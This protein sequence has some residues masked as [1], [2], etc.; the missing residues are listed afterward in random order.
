MNIFIILFSTVYLFSQSLFAET[1]I[2]TDDKNIV[3]GKRIY[4]K[5][6][7][8]NNQFI[9]SLDQGNLQSGGTRTACSNCHRRSGYG[10]SEGGIQIP[11][12]T[13]KSLFNPRDFQYKELKENINRPITRKAYSESSLERAI[14]SGIDAN[15]RALNPIMP[16]YNLSKNE[17]H[18]LTQYLK[19]LGETKNT[20]ISNTTIHFATI[21]TPGVSEKRKSAML[22]VLNA[23]V[24]S[25]NANT[26]LEERRSN[27]SP[28]HKQWSYESYR[29]WKLHIWELTGKPDQWESQLKT[30]YNNQPVFSI[31]SGISNTTW[32]PVHD[33]CNIKSI[34][35]L[36]PTTN[37]PGIS[38]DNHYAI[39]FTKGITLEAQC[40]AKHISQSIDNEKPYKIIQIVDD[41]ENNRVAANALSLQLNDYHINKTYNININDHEKI[42]KQLRSTTASN[43]DQTYLV[44]WSHI[45]A[46]LINDSDKSISL[47]NVY[48][49]QLTSL[50]T[51]RE[52]F[53]DHFSLP[54]NIYLSYP[55]SLPIN[56]D[57][58]LKRMNIW[59]RANKVTPVITDIT[60]NAYFAIT[61]LAKGIQHI[62]SNFSQ[63]YLIERIEH[64][65]DNSVF[66]SVYPHLS[67][68]PGQR[69]AS[70]GSYI[71]G[72]ISL[73]TDANIFKTT[74]WI[75]PWHVNK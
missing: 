54:T 66:H 57:K 72:P 32:Q 69:Y 29:N 48:L 13:G 51:F 6:I 12:I 27:K 46:G 62:K 33:F 35:C 19:T 30:L 44:I 22:S 21:I 34:P 52:N 60:A 50:D 37:L 53:R 9:T 43:R 40:I 56:M 14:V 11:S 74:T 61:L 73:A 42:N 24:K 31:V 15:D 25:K 17:M 47:K 59:A 39:Y 4:Q 55:H 41:T 58:H 70:K 64:M 20:S 65:V 5:G 7:G 45:P 26:R 10:S 28:W 67:L 16:R 68:G 2:D 1:N 3:I 23:F 71:I 38:K 36:F 18:S 75:V 8:E 49:P 63:D